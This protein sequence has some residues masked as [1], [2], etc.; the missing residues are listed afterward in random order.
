MALIWQ[1][2][3]L[4]L[5]RYMPKGERLRRGGREA[6][7]SDVNDTI[8]VQTSTLEQNVRTKLL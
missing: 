2:Q 4:E 5:E 8:V 3:G 7:E 6:R 1:R